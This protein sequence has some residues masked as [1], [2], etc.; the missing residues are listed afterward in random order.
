MGKW[1]DED[2][3]PQREALRNLVAFWVLGFVNNI[4]YVIM[5]AGAQEIAAGGVGLV[6]F[7][8][9]FPALL[10]KLTGPY[11]FHLFSYR[12]RTY[13]A[14]LWMLMSFIV[15]A[16]GTHSLGLQLLGVAFSG[17]QS[18][19]MEASF[20]AMASF[21]DA[22][23]CLTCWSSGTGLAGVGGYAWVAIFHLWLGLSFSTTL[24]LASIFPVLYVF[25]F[26]AVLDTTRLPVPRRA[27]NQY[28]AIPGAT[29]VES[30][31]DGNSSYSRNGSQSLRSPG[32]DSG[33][34]MGAAA[35]S[36]SEKLRFVKT[37]GPYMIP[38]VVVYFAEYTMQ[39]GVWSTI[40]FPVTSAEARATFYS[41]AG[42]AYQSGVF[43]SRSSGVLF[44]AT[45]PVLYLMP[46]LQTALLVFFTLVSVF[47]FWYNW[48]LLV[49][50]FLA[51]LLGGGVY[52]NAF[53]L[54]SREVPVSHVEFALSAASISDTLGIMAADFAGL[55][56]QGCL[57]AVNRLPGAT[58]QVSC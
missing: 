53:T 26:T 7:F 44:Q 13:V 43:I 29:D 10:V 51:G 34:V 25:I 39:T 6:Y 24:V 22:Q 36:F 54:L 4:G 52:V 1:H 32:A 48:S 21:Y 11:W 31:L 19:M 23:R 17:L 55:Y 28:T 41:S 30:P 46:A 35:L 49:F 56:L 14:A 57:Y 50:C 16:Y 42:M 12:H 8:D 33:V 47:H 27:T 40:G 5:I 3:P 18:G 37:L 45:R 15:V 20:L 38:L 9:I 58:V 2:A